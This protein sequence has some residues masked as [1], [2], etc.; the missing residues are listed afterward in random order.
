M[1]AAFQTSDSPLVSSSSWRCSTSSAGGR[2][3]PGRPSPT[4]PPAPRR[5]PNRCTTSPTRRSTCSSQ[6]EERS[7]ST[8]PSSKPVRHI[9][10]H[11]FFFS[12]ARGFFQLPLKKIFL[13]SDITYSALHARCCSFKSRR[14][15]NAAANQ[16]ILFCACEKMYR[17]E[18]AG[19]NV[20]V[21]VCEF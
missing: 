21:C 15:T 5:A 7:K 20:C 3:V 13:F 8:R 1:H 19:G 14:L 4:A 18:T 11:F 2:G 9:P 17:V 12:F 16:H 6:S 10:V